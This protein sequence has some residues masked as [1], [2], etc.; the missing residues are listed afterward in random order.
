MY[1]WLKTNDL[2]GFNNNSF[3]GVLLFCQ[4]FERGFVAQA[5]NLRR[6]CM[7]GSRIK[8]SIFTDYA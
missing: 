2:K 3:N 5:S 1:I 8:C 4:T 7:S 6:M